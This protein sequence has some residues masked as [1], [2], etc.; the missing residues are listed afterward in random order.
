MGEATA[1]GVS[2][3]PSRTIRTKPTIAALKVLGPRLAR[4]MDVD[5]DLHG[6]E[7]GGK[8]ADHPGDHGLQ[9][10]VA[11]IAQ[12]GQV[13]PPLAGHD[14]GPCRAGARG[15][16]A[17]GDGAAIGDP[18]RPI[19]LG[20]SHGSAVIQLQSPQP[21]LGEVREPQL[22][23][24][25]PGGHPLEPEPVHAAG[26]GRSVRLAVA[27]EVHLA[28]L[29]LGRYQAG[30]GSRVAAEGEPHSR[31][32]GG[33]SLELS[34]RKEP[35]LLH[36]EPPRHDPVF[37]ALERHL[38]LPGDSRIVSSQREGQRKSLSYPNRRRRLPV[39]QGWRLV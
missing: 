6:E 1:S 29:D 12:A 37:G 17:M 25:V 14:G 32:S 35:Q 10:A 28:L 26:G 3:C 20:R 13:Q 39:S 30:D 11:P 16:P 23:Q 27:V 22:H 9:V 33:P 21:Q 18:F 38:A 31:G 34:G 7:V 36:G 2:G 15:R 19:I 24:L 5:A 4:V 8:T